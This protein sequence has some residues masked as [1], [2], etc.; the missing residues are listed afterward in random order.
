MQEPPEPEVPEPESSRGPQAVLEPGAA[1][2]RMSTAIDACAREVRTAS[3]LSSAQVQILRLALPGCSLGT[4]MERLDIPK[5]TAAGL[6]DRL[7]ISGLI[8]RTT[9]G[10]DRRRQVIHATPRGAGHLARFDA[11]LAAR[12][13]QLLDP[14]S[15]SR[16]ER[17]T[18]LLSRIPAATEPDT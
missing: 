16:R 15:P 1:I 11:R 6:V 4:I 18:A 14:L 3:L 13:R 17:L 5:S 10:N 7:V 9:D 2:I 8:R 12:V